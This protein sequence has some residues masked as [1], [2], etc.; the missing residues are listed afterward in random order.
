MTAAQQ[1][2]T[3]YPYDSHW[4]ARGHE[5]AGETVAGFLRDQEECSVQWTQ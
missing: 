2:V 4:D 1:E 3:Y 5:I